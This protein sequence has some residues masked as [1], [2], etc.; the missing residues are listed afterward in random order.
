ML[1]NVL[2]PLTDDRKHFDSVVEAADV[3]TILD[4][5]ES[6]DGFAA[7]LE[8]FLHSLP[9]KGNPRSDY[10]NNTTDREHVRLFTDAVH[11]VA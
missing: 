10:A 2:V 11:T 4:I 1:P 9:A 7:A 5:I 8:R 6:L 3:A